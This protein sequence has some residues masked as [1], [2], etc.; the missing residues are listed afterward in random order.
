M[1]YT[2]ITCKLGN[3]HE[4]ARELLMAEL[5]NA[6]FES[7]VET[8][9]AIEA[10]I[11]SADF[12]PELLTADNLQ[13]NE[14]FSFQYTAEVIADQ[15]WNEVWEQNYFEPLLIED[16]CTIRAPFHDSYPAAKFEIII[17]PRMAFGTGNHETTHLMI[18]TMLEQ[19]LEGK[20]ILDMGCGSGIL[21]ILSSMKGAGEITA[22]DIDEWST[23]NTLENAALNNISNILVRSGDADLLTDQQFEVVLANIQRNILLHDMHAYRKVLKPGGILIMSGFYM[24]DLDAIVV[25]ANSLGLRLERS[26]ERSDWCAACFSVIHGK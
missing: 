11:R 20:N 10:Y 9:D 15:N 12:T 14:F 3:D 26:Y 25:K 2:K 19:N 16:Q 18:K 5:G 13:R 17:F 6:G 8:D 7:F 21:S 23:N 22:I 4:L 24:T 1:E